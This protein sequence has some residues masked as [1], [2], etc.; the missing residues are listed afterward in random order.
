M[1]EFG[2]VGEG[3]DRHARNREDMTK[4]LREIGAGARG[5]Q[6]TEADAHTAGGQGGAAGEQAAAVGHEAGPAAATGGGTTR[7]R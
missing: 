2:R 1:A 3:T 6:G 4:R 5:A 7:G